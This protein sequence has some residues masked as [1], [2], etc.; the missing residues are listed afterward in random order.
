MP[1]PVHGRH[2]HGCRGFLTSHHY[3]FL[4]LMCGHFFRGSLLS[5]SARRWPR[6]L[7]GGG[8]SSL[9][10]PTVQTYCS[11]N[12]FCGF[13]P[14]GL[15]RRVCWRCNAVS[16][17]WNP[18]TQTV[19]SRRR[20]AEGCKGGLLGSVAAA[21]GQTK[22]NSQL[23]WGA[24]SSWGRVPRRLCGAA[25]T[26]SLKPGTSSW[27]PWEPSLHNKNDATVA[28]PAKAHHAAECLV[29]VGGCQG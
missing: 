16:D 2:G 5:Y 1:V 29:A 4:V 27:Q 14:R 17:C 20:L 9:R 26:S 22:K 28:Q 10:S 13:L 18:I 25:A 12:F 3:D 7:P 23:L 21:S 8:P 24:R 19:C 6:L 11:P 15:L